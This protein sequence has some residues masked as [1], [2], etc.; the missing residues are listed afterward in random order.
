MGNQEKIKIIKKG[1]TPPNVPRKPEKKEDA[2]YTPP[3]P[4][5]PPKKPSK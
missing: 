5:P 4:P 1:Y 3:P 2:G